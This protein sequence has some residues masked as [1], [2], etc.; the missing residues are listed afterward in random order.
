MYIL[1]TPPNKPLAENG[2]S[3]FILGETLPKIGFGLIFT[4]RDL[5]CPQ[6]WMHFHFFESPVLAHSVFTV[7]LLNLLQN[8]PL[9]LLYSCWL[10]LVNV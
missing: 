5:P 8:L 2:L 1:R 6:F 9:I 10:N 3:A 7:C 4:L